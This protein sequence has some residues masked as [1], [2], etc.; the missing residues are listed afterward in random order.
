MAHAACFQGEPAVDAER[1]HYM[2]ER[3]L[4]LIRFNNLEVLTETEGV[5]ERTWLE[6]RGEASP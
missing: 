3:G 5:P 1:I 6:V 2:E 4:R